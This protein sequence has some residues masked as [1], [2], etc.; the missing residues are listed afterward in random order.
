M[1]FSWGVC[2]LPWQKHGE[3]F[4][5]I[6]F[7]CKSCLFGQLDRNPVKWMFPIKSSIS[8]FNIKSHLIRL[9][10]SF[11]LFFP[12]PSNKLH[13]IVND[14]PS[15]CL[16]HWWDP[17]EKEKSCCPVKPLSIYSTSVEN[18]KVVKAWVA[19]QLWTHL[20]GIPYFSLGLSLG[21]L[22]A[23]LVRYAGVNGRPSVWSWE[24]SKD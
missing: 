24:G 8:I 9:S 4:D 21:G 14:L 7:R 11:F 2:P 18:L 6:H 19:E 23:G 22:D 13:K 5:Q 16:E 17:T 3:N 1:L 10:L 15:L 12:L 20:Q